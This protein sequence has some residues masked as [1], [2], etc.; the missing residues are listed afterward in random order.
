MKNW[1]IDEFINE[2][3]KLCRNEYTYDYGNMPEGVCNGHIVKPCTNFVTSIIFDGCICDLGVINEKYPEGNTRWQVG[4]KSM[5]SL[6]YVRYIL[7][8]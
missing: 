1:R 6:E 5:T 2:C 4:N 3:E 8:Q 7:E